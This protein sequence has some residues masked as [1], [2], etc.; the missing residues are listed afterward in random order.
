MPQSSKK[1]LQHRRV[2]PKPLVPAVSTLSWGCLSGDPLPP[3]VGLYRVLSPEL[4]NLPALVEV[5]HPTDPLRDTLRVLP[6]SSPS[7]LKCFQLQ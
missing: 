1:G 2:T 4:N 3:A 5:S 7:L 6:A